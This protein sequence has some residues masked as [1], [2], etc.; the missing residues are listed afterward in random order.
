MGGAQ[1]ALPGRT[2]ILQPGIDARLTGQEPLALP[3]GMP[4]RQT[5]IH[6]QGYT[7]ELIQGRHAF[8]HNLTRP[9][10]E[11]T[12]RNSQK[13]CAPR[14]YVDPRQPTGASR[15]RVRNLIVTKLRAIRGSIRPDMP[16]ARLTAPCPVGGAPQ[17]ARRMMTG[18]TRGV[19]TTILYLVSLAIVHLAS[20][21][22]SD[23]PVGWAS[24]GVVS[25]GSAA[26]GL[27]TM[28]TDPRAE[29]DPVRREGVG[30][31]HREY[32]PVPRY[33]LARTFAGLDVGRYSWW[34]P[35][36]LAVRLVGLLAS[37]LGNG[38]GCWATARNRFFSTS[39]TFHIGTSSTRPSSEDDSESRGSWRGGT[40]TVTNPPVTVRRLSWSTS[41]WAVR[42]CAYQ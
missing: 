35:R 6:G 12:L 28:G 3:E 1:Q 40:G 33:P 8:L 17:A 39:E 31:G 7:G 5:P 37:T 22:R 24:I 23:W 10:R 13:T 19:R 42:E 18:S 26:V 20:A 14:R 27:H 32:L 15:P 29:S 4:L 21:G 11:L 34:P 38:L 2:S 16:S 41:S 9:K 36:A 25:V 30:R